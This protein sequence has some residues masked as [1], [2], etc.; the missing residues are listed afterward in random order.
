MAS[1]KSKAIE[2]GNGQNKKDVDISALQESAGEQ[3][4][5]L[6][7]QSHCTWHLNIIQLHARIIAKEEISEQEVNPD[8]LNFR[9][10][11]SSFARIEKVICPFSTKHR[12]IS[13]SLME[14]DDINLD[15]FSRH[16]TRKDDDF[17]CMFHVIDLP[18]AVI[19]RLMLRSIPL[20]EVECQKLF[21]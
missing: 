17:P 6:P 11:W 13:R 19:N 9:Q 18:F 12:E 21:D 14:S 4:I 3:G 5:N 15:G 2:K 8:E 16:F 20:Q 10:V 1:K 7:D